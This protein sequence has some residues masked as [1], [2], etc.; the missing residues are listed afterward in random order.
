MNDAL[1]GGT[2]ARETPCSEAMLRELRESLHDIRNH[3]NAIHGLVSMMLLQSRDVSAARDR[4]LVEEQSEQLSYPIERLDLHGPEGRDVQHQGDDRPGL[5]IVARLARH[6]GVGVALDS[7]PD[8]G[9]TVTV[10]VP[11]LE[12]RPL[13]RAA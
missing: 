1:P 9:T 12:R 5:R 8:E 2:D 3:L 10:V 4:P 7:E 13:S 11:S 6:F